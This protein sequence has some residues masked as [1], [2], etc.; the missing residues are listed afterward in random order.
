[1]NMEQYALKIVYGL[2]VATAIVSL[3]IAIYQYIFERSKIYLFTIYYWLSI[4]IS[5]F[6]NFFVTDK[7]S[8]FYLLSMTCTFTSESLLSLIM[9]L[10]RGLTFNFRF[11]LRIYFVSTILS[12]VF[13]YAG[14]SF[15]VYVFINLIGA[16]FPVFYT[17][18]VSLKNKKPPFTSAQTLFYL[19][20]IILSLHYLD[21]PFFKSDS[22]LFTI[23]SAI[24]FFLFHVIS[25]MIPMAV[26]EYHLHIKNLNLETEI[27]KRILELRQKDQQLWESNKQEV[28][29]KFSGILA[30]ELNTPLSS[31]SLAVSSIQKFLNTPNITTDKIS[32]KLESIKLVIKQITA[33]TSTLRVV[34]GEQMGKKISLFDLKRI[35]LSHEEKIRELCENNQIQFS[36]QITQENCLINGNDNEMAQLFKT[37][38]L[39]SVTSIAH[40]ANRTISFEIKKTKKSCILILLDSR[41]P[42]LKPPFNEISLNPVINSEV[43]LNM[44]VIKSI[45]EAHK[46]VLEFAFTPTHYKITIELPLYNEDLN[47]KPDTFNR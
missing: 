32:E 1:M 46:G 29:G 40:Q 44:V 42:N 15:E 5:A 23:G 43:N 47:E 28:I 38:F 34:A 4:L 6:I 8:Y 27:Q 30:H 33:M 41:A 31:I 24:A 9:G 18:L 13:R 26:N 19:F 7:E 36:Y 20:C 25:A 39:N 14:Y 22:K 17:T 3:L 35:F 37:L 11:L 16:V 21:Y 2:F 10:I 12:F 45:V